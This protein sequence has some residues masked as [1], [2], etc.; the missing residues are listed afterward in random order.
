MQNNQCYLFWGFVFFLSLNSQVTLA[1]EF[2]SGNEGSPTRNLSNP[3]RDDRGIG[4][5]SSGGYEYNTAR[6]QQS[7]R[8]R[9]IPL[10]EGRSASGSSTQSS[11]GSDSDPNTY[12][13][14][15]YYLSRQPSRWELSYSKQERGP[16]YR[17]GPRATYPPAQPSACH[18]QSRAPGQNWHEFDLDIY[19]DGYYHSTRE[20]WR[21]ADKNEMRCQVSV[22]AEL[23]REGSIPLAPGQ[24]R[25][26]LDLSTKR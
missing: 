18:D 1:E 20:F 7:D 3:Y 11:S 12:G 13:T 16:I 23:I 9:A 21:R 25:A 4:S 24:R 10:P 5:S 15:A 6:R 14:S 26:R 8:G 22:D 19:I 2:F 17:G